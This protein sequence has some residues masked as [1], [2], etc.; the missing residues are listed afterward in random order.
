MATCR[1][2]RPQLTREMSIQ[3]C[4]KGEFTSRHSLEW[5]FLFLDY[6]AAAIIGYFPFEV[7]GTSGFDY[8][9]FDDLEQVVEC[10]NS[11]KFHTCFRSESH[12]TQ[13]N[14]NLIYYRSKTKGRR[15]LVLLSLSHQRPTMAVAANT[16]LHHLPSMDVQTRVCHVHTSRRQ[17]YGCD[18][19]NASEQR[20]SRGRY[21]CERLGRQCGATV[22]HFCL[23]DDDHFTDEHEEC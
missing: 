4:S 1:I 15:C 12:Q 14:V 5:K 13:T 22:K 8:C 19:A 2:C 11:R 7:L 20:K 9:H 16:L 18:S 3:G 6:G 21:G 10:H 23:V 17:L